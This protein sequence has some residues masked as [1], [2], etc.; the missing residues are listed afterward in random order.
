VYG[1]HLT[2]KKMDVDEDEKEDGLDLATARLMGAFEPTSGSPNDYHIAALTRYY[3][4]TNEYLVEWSPT[5]QKSNRVADSPI[6]HIELIAGTAKSLVYYKPTRMLSADLDEELKQDYHALHPTTVPQVAL[7]PGSVVCPDCALWFQYKANLTTHY[8]HAHGDAQTIEG[9]RARKIMSP[10]TFWTPSHPINRW[11]VAMLRAGVRSKM[12]HTSQPQLGAV[13]VLAAP[14]SV[15]VSSLVRVGDANLQIESDP[16]TG[17][18]F[19]CDVFYF[20]AVFVCTLYPYPDA[21]ICL[22]EHRRIL[23]PS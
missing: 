15:I 20:V 16:L 4:R 1:T 3:A 22:R 8:N 5:I 7:H 17:N 2:Q 19:W 14:M 6:R 18:P 13:L 10:M 9:V 11:F 21:C 23:G 12:K